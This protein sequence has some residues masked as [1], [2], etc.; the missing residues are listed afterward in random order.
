[1]KNY[2]NLLSRIIAEGERK[3]NRTGIETLSLFCPDPLRFDLREGLPILTTRKQFFSTA[4]KELLWFLR[5]ET[6]VGTLDSGIWDAWSDENGDIGPMYG[7]QL[8]N[9]NGV[10]LDQISRLIENLKT[11]PISRR[12]LITTFNPLQ[13]PKGVLWPCH[14]ISIQFNCSPCNEAG[15]VALDTPMYY[16]D[17]HMHMRSNDFILGAPT[18][19]TEYSLFLMLIAREVNMIPRYYIHTATD[20]HIYLNHLE[21]AKEQLS[22]ETRTLPR[23]EIAN[24]PIPFP[25][26]PRDCSVLEPEDFKLVGYDPWPAI[27]FEV[28]V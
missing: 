2:L 16:L 23:V 27:K 9:F 26:C 25:G 3:A 12:H 19:I 6:N 5:A 7:Y 18:N 22:R 10:G 4:V 14:G 17:M 20:L 24:K 15:F 8:R 28:A 21:G 1:V 13:A 11:D